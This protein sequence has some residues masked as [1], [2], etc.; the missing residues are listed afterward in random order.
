MRSR[1]NPEV[2]EQWC[3]TTD[4]RDVLPLNL[5][6]H[7]KELRVRGDTA[8]VEAWK[9][10]RTKVFEAVRAADKQINVRLAGDAK[11]SGGFLLDFSDM[12][13][14]T[15]TAATDS[16]VSQL[17]LAP[18]CSVSVKH[19][20]VRRIHVHSGSD[21]LDLDDCWVSHLIVSGPRT[22]LTLR[23]CWIGTLQI[24]SGALASLDV[25][26]GSIRSIMCPAP[27]DTNPIIG[28][29]YL[30]NVEF[31]T[32]RNSPTRQGAQ[33]FRNF[34]AH[35]ENL[36]NVQAANLMRAVVLKI[37]RHDDKRINKWFNYLHGALADHGEDPLRPLIVAFFVYVLA[38]GFIYA[39][40][41]GA[42][43]SDITLYTGW[44]IGLTEETYRGK[45][46]RSLVLPLQSMI[47][48]F[49]LFGGLKI[50]AAKTG[51][52]QIIMAVQGLFMDALI[53]MSFLGIRK[54][55]K[56]H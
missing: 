38:V 23:D 41:G 7:N 14:R 2:F 50:V 10:F 22:I 35:L 31:P 45:L 29:V 28:S 32:S 48:P 5:E 18:S 6:H 3:V 40:D 11:P 25:A 43:R 55:F 46:S 37:E 8:M 17:D 53:A 4:P 33:G 16:H 42:T 36:E 54:R 1:P 12:W 21:R 49:G 13:P 44:Q 19:G 30:S 34:R 51:L 47:N 24:S 26:G 39:A 52:I 27:Y 9:Q 20:L 15:F 56:L